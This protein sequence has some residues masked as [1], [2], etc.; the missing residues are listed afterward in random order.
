MENSSFM[1]EESRKMFK[2]GV[3]VS[4]FGWID[5]RFPEVVQCK[6][7][8]QDRILEGHEKMM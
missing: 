7:Y 1:V 4:V 6:D 2:G 8:E 3:R 5:W